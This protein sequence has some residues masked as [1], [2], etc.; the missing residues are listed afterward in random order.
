M[1]TSHNIFPEIHITPNP[2][3]VI[4][5]IGRFVTDRLYS[6]VPNTGAAPYLDERLETYTQLELGE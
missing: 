1:E 4:C 6:D 3:D 2:L 5:K